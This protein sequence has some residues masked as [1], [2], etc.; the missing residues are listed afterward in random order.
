MKQALLIYLFIFSNSIFAQSNYYVSTSGS[1]LNSGTSI[2]T[3]WKTIQK[4][5]NTATP[6]SI[7]NILAG[8]YN[9]NV[10]VNVSGTAGNEIVF[11]NYLNDIVTIDGTATSGKILLKISN[12]NHLKFE[13]IIIQN[14]TVNDAQGILVETTGTNSSTNLT[15]SNIKIRNINW[16]TNPSTVPTSTKNAQGFIAYGRN[17][18]ITNLTL[19]NVEVYNNILGFSEALAIN[20]NIDGFSIKNCLVHDNNNIGIDILG[21]EGTSTVNDQARNGIVSQNVCYNNISPYATSAGIYV[22]GATNIIIERNKCYQNGWGIEIGAEQ[23]GIVQ[24]IDVKN[25][26]IFGNQQAGLSI[27]GYNVATTGQ[28]KFCTIRNN[29]FYQN[30]TLN[31]GT[32]EISMTK[33]SNCI[34][35]N[36]I[37]Y[38]NQQNTFMTVENITPQASNT[39]NYNNWFSPNNNANNITVNWRNTTY[40]SFSSYKTGTGQESNSAFVNPLLVSSNDFRLQATSNC[41]NSGNPATSISINEADYEGLNRL[42]GT[43]IDKGAHEYGSSLGTYDLGMNIKFKIFPNPTNDLV[44]ITS[45]EI[46]NNFQIFTSNGE[47]ILQKE[48]ENLTEIVDISK[49]S[50]GLYLL[51]IKNR[52]SE[53]T[54]KIIKK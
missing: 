15:F 31:D 3:A 40:T 28:V 30:N 13:N 46:M 50:S 34:F 47:L 27:G 54:F 9:E 35:E 4:A 6:N 51:K 42:S 1:D 32:G 39:F 21:N 38:T 20:G 49:F 44:Y 12:K 45:S 2:L 18:G 33:A 29:T 14:K 7:V 25:N 52:N 19:D 37:F 43:E 53:N 5:A 24:Q 10:I 8:T 36:N 26:L 23:N 22:D 17:G 11:K 48:I 41:V 16:T